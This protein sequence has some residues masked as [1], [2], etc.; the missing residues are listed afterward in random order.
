MSNSSTLNVLQ[1]QSNERGPERR[2]DH[3]VPMN[4][5]L[6]SSLNNG[7]QGRTAASLFYP[8]LSEKTF[9]FG[10]AAFEVM[11]FLSNLVVQLKALIEKEGGEQPF[12]QWLMRTDFFIFHVARLTAKKKRLKVVAQFGYFRDLINETRVIS[13]LFYIIS[14]GNKNYIYI[15][16]LKIFCLLEGQTGSGTRILKGVSSAFILW[17]SIME[18][19]CFCF[20]SADRLYCSLQRIF[21][22]VHIVI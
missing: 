7:V 19:T 8:K 14:S 5:H 10:K 17:K 3:R 16:M 18:T 6:S 21:F 9:T 2:P 11:A 12:H 22:L 4:L 15:K 20:L 13:V 1:L